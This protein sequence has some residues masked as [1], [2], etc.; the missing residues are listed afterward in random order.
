MVL[1]DT[2]PRTSPLMN[3][4]AKLNQNIEFTKKF[5]PNNYPLIQKLR[6]MEPTENP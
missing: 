2:N 1:K 5:T 3:N 6:D 4:I